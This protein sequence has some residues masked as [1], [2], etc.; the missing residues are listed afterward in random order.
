MV[1]QLFTIILMISI[2]PRDPSLASR[3]SS[4]RGRRG[5]TGKEPAADTH[6][7]IV[8]DTDDEPPHSSQVRR[9]RYRFVIIVSLLFKLMLMISNTFRDLSPAKKSSDPAPASR[10]SSHIR[11]RGSTGKE[12]ATDTHTSIVDD[13]DD[14]PPRSSQVRRKKYRCHHHCFS[15]IQ[16]DANEIKHF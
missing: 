16:G 3:S 4:H 15:A 12:P 11:R 9:K 8:D 6:T 13:M 7:S 14:E 10:S 1:S 2:I 5:S